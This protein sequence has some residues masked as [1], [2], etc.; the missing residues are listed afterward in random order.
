[1][2]CRG[3]W[4]GFAQLRE[5]SD[6]P[7]PPV[8]MGA[9]AWADAT[10]RPASRPSR[11]IIIANARRRRETRCMKPKPLHQ[12]PSGTNTAHQLKFY[13]PAPALHR[14]TGIVVEASC[15][16]DIPR[17]SPYHPVS[18]QHTNQSQPL[19]DG[20]SLGQGESLL[21]ALF[22]NRSTDSVRAGSSC[23]L[24]K[25]YGRLFCVHLHSWAATREVC[26]YHHRQKCGGGAGG[27]S[28]LLGLS[29]T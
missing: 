3:G 8:S 22:E 27:V 26:L 28:A 6:D 7:P 12:T 29:L 24:C 1:M 10:P 20:D 16:L 4:R 23:K 2:R 17:F 14:I 11:T 5:G 13:L 19:G 15:L 9:S 18:K 21:T 25:L